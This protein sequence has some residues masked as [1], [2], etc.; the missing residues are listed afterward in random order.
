MRICIV[1]FYYRP[2]G[3]GI[4]RYVE[5][6]SKSLAELGN[7][8]DIITASYEK[9]EKTEVEGRIT[10]YY[11]P[12]MNIFKKTSQECFDKSREFLE[13]L[14]IYLDKNEVDIIVAQNMHAAIT[15]VSHSFVLNM[16][17]I[18]KDIPLILTIH[19]FPEEDEYSQLK[20]SLVKNLFWD[21]IV[22]VSSAVAEIFCNK[23]VDVER[24]K[25]IPPGVDVR[26]F[27]P[28][29]GKKWLKSRVR[30]LEDKDVVI[31]HASSMFTPKIAE[32]KGIKTL[33]KAFSFIAPRYK[34]VKILIAS[35][36]VAP[37]F[38]NSNKKTLAGINNTI[39]LY[40]LQERVKTATFQ[41]EDMP[42]VYNGCDIFV[43]A[44]RIESFGLVY[45]EAMACGLPVI[46]TSVGGIPEVIING[47]CGYLVPPDNPVELSKYLSLLVS[48]VAKREKFG[49]YGR[50]IV[51]SKFDANKISAKRIGNYR[52]LVQYKNKK[53]R[54]NIF[55]Q[56]VRE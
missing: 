24:I 29:L 31:L 37:P 38:E 4:P 15:S 17:A 48:D 16:A 49:D 56:I 2:A 9:E 26:L 25:V 55:E 41:P 6:L 28:G 22:T 45:A 30:G 19:S 47:Q 21:R 50:K 14:K 43:L 7:D 46:G 5:T 35:A 18:E 34:N 42:L 39:R 32:D 8:I 27:K 40:N 44:S 11:L 3:G 12:S 33:L 13:F 36:P 1:T 52:S 20:L 23:G 10:T 53:K 51:L 54:F